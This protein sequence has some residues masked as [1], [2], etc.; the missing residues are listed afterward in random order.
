MESLEYTYIPGLEDAEIFEA[1]APKLAP[2]ARPHMSI[3]RPATEDQRQLAVPVFRRDPVS[4][5]C[6]IRLA[7][8]A[9]YGGI[10]LGN[11][12]GNMW[13]FPI[14]RLHESFNRWSQ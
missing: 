12:L 11:N 5:L 4:Y 7:C 1:F 13:S 2:L 6:R 8:E 10:V 14:E 3:F 9:L